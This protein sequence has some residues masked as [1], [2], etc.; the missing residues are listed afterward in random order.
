MFAKKQGKIIIPS[1]LL[2]YHNFSHRH[3]G[4]MLFRGKKG[5][6]RTLQNK[7]VPRDKLKQATLKV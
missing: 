4:F 2:Y 1:L 5:S 3:N 6:S 7:N